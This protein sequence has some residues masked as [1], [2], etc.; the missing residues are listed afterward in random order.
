MSHFSNSHS[1]LKY[2]QAQLDRLPSGQWT[3]CFLFNKGKELSF[4]CRKLFHYKLNWK[5][6]VRRR[7]GDKSRRRDMAP[8]FGAR[9]TKRRILAVTVGILAA[10]RILVLSQ[11][12]LSV[13]PLV[14]PD[15]KHWPVRPSACLAVWPPRLPLRTAEDGGAPSVHYPL[16]PCDARQVRAHRLRASA[17]PQ[18]KQTDRVL[19]ALPPARETPV[20]DRQQHRQHQTARAT[21][22]RWWKRVALPHSHFRWVSERVSVSVCGNWHHCLHSLS[23][24]LCLFSLPIPSWTSS[25]GTVLFII[26]TIITGELPPPPPPPPPQFKWRQECVRALLSVLLL[27]PHRSLLQQQELR[28]TGCFSGSG[29]GTGCSAAAT[30]H[31]VRRRSAC[32]CS[33]CLPAWLL[34][35]DCQPTQPFTAC[36]CVSASVS[37]HCCRCRTVFLFFFLFS[38]LFGYFFSFFQC[39]SSPPVST[40]FFTAHPPQRFTTLFQWVLGPVIVWQGQRRRIRQTFLHRNNIWHIKLYKRCVC[41]FV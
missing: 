8:T 19:P 33:L 12:P 9:W 17:P 27:L 26:K 1:P 30:H 18:R 11:L 29:T 23:L 31:S 34:L 3:Q 39:D 25:S 5:K 13:C 4:L 20:G 14:T 22:L 38:S 6:S 41:V 7:G 10:I 28:C 15:S 35:L 16:L 2:C 32:L 37:V 24:S 36:L 21:Q 40:R